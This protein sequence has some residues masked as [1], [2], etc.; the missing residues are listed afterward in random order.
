MSIS[1]R[2][3]GTALPF[4][5]ARFC[6]MLAGANDISKVALAMAVKICFLIQYPSKVLQYL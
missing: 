1:T 3:F 4:T 2:A 6:A 5:M